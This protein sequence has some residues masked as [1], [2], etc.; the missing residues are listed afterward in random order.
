MNDEIN[1]KVEEIREAGASLKKHL[2]GQDKIDSISLI[3]KTFIIGGAAL[4]LVWFF[5][6]LFQRPVE[7]VKKKKKKKKKRNSLIFD[8]VKDQLGIIILALFRKQIQQILRDF[9]LIDEK[10]DIQGNA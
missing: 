1:K 3:N 10:E 4:L 6:K 2:N 5:S 9:K 7:D 8:L